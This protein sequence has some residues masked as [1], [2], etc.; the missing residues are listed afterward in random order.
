MTDDEKCLLVANS[1][2]I[3]IIVEN[4]DNFDDAVGSPRKMVVI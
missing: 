1:E 2:K 3:T 4:S